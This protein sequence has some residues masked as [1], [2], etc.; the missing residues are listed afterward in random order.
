MKM[1]LFPHK[2][3]KPAILV[4]LLSQISVFVYMVIRTLHNPESGLL[5][6][7]GDTVSFRIAL[8]LY[9][10]AVYGSLFVILFSKE[11]VEDEY[12][13]RLRLES[14]AIVAAVIISLGFIWKLIECFL[15]LDSFKDYREMV[16]D[17]L[18]G[19]ILWAPIIYFCV[20][21]YKLRHLR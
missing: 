9:A 19:L 14:V 20:F 13:S 10:L 8:V 1:L 11:K 12:I 15:P 18:S 5:P 21:K 3:Q 6:F 16:R 2:L 17:I 4:F 7:T